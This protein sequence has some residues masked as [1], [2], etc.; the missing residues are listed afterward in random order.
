MMTSLYTAPEID[1]DN[2]KIW[3]PEIVR[4]IRCRKICSCRSIKLDAEITLLEEP[5]IH[6]KSKKLLCH[7]GNLLVDELVADQIA[8]PPA[9][10]ESSRLWEHPRLHTIYFNIQQ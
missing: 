9:T 3:K 8:I 7:A 4:W 1:A 2:C 6:I 10:P 5:E